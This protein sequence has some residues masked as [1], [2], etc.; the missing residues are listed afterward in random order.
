M[1][2][3]SLIK[4]AVVAA[5]AAQ[6][7]CAAVLSSAA[8]L[9]EFHTRVHALDVQVEG[10]ADS[11]LGAVQD[12]EDVDASVTIDPAELKLP[13]RDIFAV[14]NQ[15]GR[16]L[17]SSPG[18]PPTLIVREEAGFREV[19]LQHEKYRVF[20]RDA[21]RVIDRAEYGGVGLRRPVTLVYAVPEGHLR[22]EV[23][24]ATSFYIVTILLATGAMAFALPPLLRRTLRPLADLASAAG[25]IHAP[26][27][28]FDPPASAMELSELRPL[29]QVLNDSIGRVRASFAREH[30]FV[31]D[32]A[33][34]L[35]TAVAV[36]RSSAQLLLL[37]RRSEMEYEA[38]LKEVVDDVE[39][40]ETLIAQML[41]LARVEEA[42]EPDL[43]T[44]DL[45]DAVT[46]VV[47]L[48][49][50]VADQRQV[51]VEVVAK[52]GTRVRMRQ[53]AA[54]TLLSNLLM[55]ALQ[56]STA[57]SPGIV[58]SVVQSTAQSV[59]LS[60][61]DG[62]SGISP[63]ALPYVFERFYR[64]D[65]SRSRET[66]GTGLGLAIAKSIV[67]S[68]GGSIR[69]ESTPGVGTTMHVTFITA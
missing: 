6:L 49:K 7:L 25:E 31:S 11:L 65:R 33:H 29:T 17:G 9:H 55:N 58:I 34:E 15:G 12:A 50:P 16:L 47:Q 40:L 27:F 2:G 10:R 32:A 18:A 19:S 53:D 37:R 26:A 51:T 36:I 61:A 21:V 13:P 43:P 54:E 3:N 63:E 8:L 38:G 44:I 22:H 64:E 52:S 41:E 4:R 30:Q 5:I 35:K 24:E 1:K 23:F 45:A 67:E 42:R 69:V 62:G 14:Y 60:V 20:Q 46:R 66:G 28:P 39:R 48:V 68:A 59:Q 57:T 56:H